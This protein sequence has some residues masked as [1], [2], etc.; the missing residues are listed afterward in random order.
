MTDHF[1]LKN[2]DFKDLVSEPEYDPEKF[3]SFTADF[4]QQ[5]YAEVMSRR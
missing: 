1:A 4:I 5:R 2:A 3:Q